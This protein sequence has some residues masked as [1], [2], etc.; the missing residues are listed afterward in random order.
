[1]LSYSVI[2][3][4]DVIVVPGPAGKKIN[5]KSNWIGGIDFVNYQ[6]KLFSTLNPELNIRWNLGIL[7]DHLDNSELIMN[8]ASVRNFIFNKSDLNVKYKDNPSSQHGCLLNLLIKQIK[9]DHSRFL[10]I[11]DPDFF[12]IS[13]NWISNLVNY[14]EQK[15]VAIIG[16]SYPE[17]NCRMYF[18]FPTAL[19]SIIDT[20]HLSLD[21][22]DYLP[23]ENQIVASSRNDWGT[24]FAINLIPYRSSALSTN[25]ILYTFQELFQS[26]FHW[27]SKKSLVRDVGWKIRKKFKFRVKHEEFLFIENVKNEIMN[28]SHPELVQGVDPTFYLNKY[29]DIAD[30]GIDPVKHFHD[31]GK[32]EWRLPK[33]INDKS[34]KQHIFH[35]RPHLKSKM[36]RYVE[37]FYS[38]EYSVH[39]IRT[40]TFERLEKDM[41]RNVLKILKELPEC[42]AYYFFW[43]NLMAFHLGHVY[44]IGDSESILKVIDSYLSKIGIKVVS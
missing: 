31:H 30:A 19:C 10:V 35:L 41:D 36:L 26:I 38:S 27:R 6:I 43:D 42:A 1:M 5:E 28:D 32:S 22:L 4:I 2:T 33:A 29:K 24:E 12:V 34:E 23:D 20:Q 3:D 13:K 16:A 9:V 15:S 37:Y 7:E 14:M 40:Y 44:K 17:T 39:H 8:D 25:K 18:D 11:I 21:L